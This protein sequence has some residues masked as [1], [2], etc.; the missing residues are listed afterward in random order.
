MAQQDI[1]IGAADAKQGDTYFDAFTKVQ[2]NTT[3]VF[4]RLGDNVI[5]VK[6]DNIGDLL[7]GVIDSTKV[8]FLDGII[9]VTGLGMSIEI[10]A[11]G[12]YITGYNFDISGIKC[13]D[14]GFTLFKS[15]VGGSGNILF[16]DFFIELSGVGASM[17]DIK[18]ATGLEAVEVDK[19]NFNNCS[20]LGVIDNYRQGLETGTGRLGGKPELTL[21]GNWVGG[22]FID[23]SIVRFLDDGAYSLFKAGTG[24][25]MNSRFRSNQNIDLPA[26]VSFLDFSVVNFVNPS[27]LQLDGCIVTRNG[28]F[29]ATDTNII[30]N[31]SA[32]DLVSEWMGNNGID[33]TF[34]GAEATVSTEVT[35]VIS[36]IGVYVD[37]AG[38]FAETELT[39]FDSPANGQ[40]RHLG[41]SPREYQLGAQ[42]VVDG[43]ANDVVSIKAVVFRSATTSFVDGKVQKRVVNSLQ[44]GRDV[45][46]YSYFDNITLNKDDYVKFQVA[47]ESGTGNVTAELDSSF[48]VQSR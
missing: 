13:D 28:V 12:I 45:A 17:Y 23:T 24:F 37:L 31:I 16:N 46:Y 3:E 34:V 18:G 38:T 9:D 11:T 15:P 27:T 4:S 2:A 43:V 39:H 14:A 22:Y 20:S 33:N 44:G 21:A 25:V 6:Q 19:L 48:I 5:I 42:F 29:D 41:N 35:T 30:P 40:L 47:N 7:G 32:S 1:N 10:P 36:S 8:Y 26:N